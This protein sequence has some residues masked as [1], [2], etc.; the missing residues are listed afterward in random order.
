MG[1]YWNN[2]GQWE[3]ISM[4]THSRQVLLQRLPCF[5]TFSDE[6]LT[7]LVGLCTEIT[8]VQDQV[9]VKENDLVDS[10]YIIVYGKAEIKRETI[11]HRQH[12]SVLV[13]VMEEGD[14]IGLNDS[15]FYSTSGK[16]T[17]TVVAVTDMRLLRLDMQD[18]DAFLARNHLADA[19]HSAAVQMLRMRFIKQSM[20]FSKLCHERLRWLADQV[21]ERKVP[22]GTVI[23]EQGT[24]GQEC[25]L[26]ESGQVD[27]SM[28]DETG[29]RVI[30]SLKPP[31]LFGEAALISQLPRNATAT[32][33]V[34]TNLLILK[35]E[36]LATLIEN[37][38]NVAN[39]LMTLSVDR[40]RPL[41]N[42][43]VTQHYRTTADQQEMIILKNPANGNY[44]K[45]SSEGNYIWQQLNGEQTLREITLKLMDAFNIFAP[46][47]VA[48][49]IAKLHRLGFVENI[50]VVQ[51]EENPTAPLW[52][53]W[54]SKIRNILE[55]RVAIGDANPW[56]TWIYN[57][58]VWYFFTLP[59]KLLIT[60]IIIVGMGCFAFN[61]QE[62]LLFFHYQHVSL[63]LILALLPLSLIGVVLHELGH[64]FAVKAC[65]RDVHYIGVGWYWFGPIAFTDT[66]DAWLASRKE[67]IWINFA[68]IVMDLLLAGCASIGLMLTSN[69]YVGALLWLFAL[70]TFVGAFRML[71]PLQEM[72]GYYILMDWVEKN[73]LRHRS[74]LWLVKEFP[75]CVKN[76]RLFREYKAEIYYWLSCFVYLAA[77]S[78]LT[79]TVLNFV[80]SIIGRAVSPYVSMM[81]PFL[82]V[83]FSCL[84]IIADIKNQKE[85]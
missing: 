40:S 21:E 12:L 81:I 51:H 13:A 24:I 20:S 11:H 75:L 1:I 50:D 41:R 30:A 3:R 57:K 33:I 35:H 25:F 69:A 80:F 56:L 85:D 17:A 67:R 63:L 32:A 4:D 47:L 68:G 45:L 73:R 5:S 34:E 44:F 84:S 29:E 71:S 7:E 10:I 31:T 6:Q 9:I 36:H 55:F 19:M 70:Y 62:I 74:V 64:A 26:I 48:R 79:L 39:M 49:L 38:S 78:V 59:G 37:E 82:V 2:Y 83:A 23:F 43:A 76:P 52:A 16:R 22:A 54:F 27:I 65:G 15:G 72:D 28:R 77:V 60:L 58:F 42:P 18:L 8:I 53:R 66:S 61:T 14:C 46:D